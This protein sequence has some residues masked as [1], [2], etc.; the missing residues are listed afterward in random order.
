MESRN[1]ILRAL[2][3]TDFEALAPQLVTLAVAGGEVMYEPEYEIDW[4]WFPITAVLSVVTVMSDGRTV[5]SDTVGR[6]SAVGILAAL[7]NAVSTSRTFTQIP[8]EAVRL[9]ALALRRQAAASARLRTLL[10]RH[11][12][13]NLAVAHQSV[14]CNALHDVGARIC[15]WLLMSQ[16]R[17]A[18]NMVRLTQE[19]LAFMVG[20]QRTTVTR[21]LADLA[22]KG[23]IA[24]HRGRIEILDRPGLEARVC[25]CYGTVQAN[26]E[27]LIGEAP[28]AS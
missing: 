24:K 28:L 15:R 18:S 4:V 17:T 7:G 9:P 20:V 12:L 5:E 22:A 3:R 8:G 13:A 2:S 16:D 1:H 19:Y 6:E 10:M 25:E 27:R 23:V 26:F 14:A 11:A 21:L